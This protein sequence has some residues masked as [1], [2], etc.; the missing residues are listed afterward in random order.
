VDVANVEDSTVTDNKII[1]SKIVDFTDT[2][3]ILE[4]YFTFKHIND[5]N[6]MPIIQKREYGKN[7]TIY[8][9]YRL[10][11]PQKIIDSLRWDYLDEIEFVIKDKKLICKNISKRISKKEI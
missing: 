10:N 6:L 4:N 5:Y 1:V 11:I 7:G 3:T 8:Y 2:N 9:Q